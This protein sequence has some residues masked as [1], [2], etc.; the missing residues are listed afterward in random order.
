MSSENSICKRCGSSE[1]LQVGMNVCK[2][3]PS[4]GHMFVKC[5]ACGLTLKLTGKLQGEGA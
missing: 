1:P 3:D 5:S 4:K 2:E